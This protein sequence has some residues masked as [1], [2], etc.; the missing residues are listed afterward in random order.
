HVALDGFKQVGDQVGA[1]LQL[2]IDAAPALARHLAV[3][4]QG[5]VERNRVKHDDGQH[6]QK[7]PSPHASTPGFNSIIDL[8]RRRSLTA[9]RPYAH[10]PQKSI[11]L[12]P[13]GACK[14]S[15]GR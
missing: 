12:T 14:M 8:M 15:S 7:N 10:S 5:V 13:D 1:A 11:A 2:D 9:A 3:L 6:R 4:D